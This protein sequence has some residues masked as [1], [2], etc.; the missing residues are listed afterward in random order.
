MSTRHP[1]HVGI[2]LTALV[3]A[4][5]LCLSGCFAGNGT[6]VR[7]A[8]APEADASDSLRYLRIVNDEPD[9]ADPQCTDGCYDIPLNVF[10]RLVE[11][12]QKEDGSSSFV[13]SLAQSWEISDDGLVYTFHLQE[14]VRFSNGS[15]LTAS[16]VEYTLKRLLTHPDSMAGDVGAFILDADAL[17]AGETDTLEGFRAISDLGPGFF[18]HAV[19]TLRGVSGDSLHARR[20]H[21]R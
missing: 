5:L 12:Q 18:H 19:H 14:G 8:Q 15:P 13:P 21:S 4:L 2:R 6:D 3:L 7:S 11:V 20:V 1:K 17:T 16:D 9:T 10:D